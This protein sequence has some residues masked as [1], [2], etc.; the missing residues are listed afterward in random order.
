MQR[1]ARTMLLDAIAS[2]ERIELWTRTMSRPDA[3][4]WGD[5]FTPLLQQATARAARQT[6]AGPLC[7]SQSA[8]QLELQRVNRA[9]AIA[10][11]TREP[12]FAEVTRVLRVPLPQQVGLQVGRECGDALSRARDSEQRTHL[13]ARSIVAS[14]RAH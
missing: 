4:F 11:L 7:L 13:D 6:P 10:V 8:R 2:G 12:H 9:S 14:P 1:D 5:H 3:Q